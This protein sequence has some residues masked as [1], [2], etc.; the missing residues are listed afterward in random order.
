[1]QEFYALGTSIHDKNNG[2]YF[3]FD[4]EFQKKINKLIES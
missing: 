4:D 1:M 2:Y 3:R